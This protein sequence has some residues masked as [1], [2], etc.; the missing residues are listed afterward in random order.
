MAPRLGADRRPQFRSKPR[1][2][3]GEDLSRRLA[4]L[5]AVG[6]IRAIGSALDCLGACIIGVLALP[7][8]LL[9][10]DFKIAQKGLVAISDTH[11]TAGGQ[12]QK[13]FHDI[14][15]EAI[16]ES[17]PTGWMS[18]ALDLRNMLVHR[19]RR[20][21]LSQLLPREQLIFGPDGQP[22]LRVT[23]VEQLPSEPD[24]SQVE[25]FVMV[26]GKPPV[27]TEHAGV[28]LRGLQRSTVY[29]VTKVARELV[30][31]WQTRRTTPGLLSQ[32]AAQWPRGL[33]D[34][35]TSFT[36][37]RPGSAPFEPTHMRVHPDD[38]HRL[39]SAALDDENRPRWTSFDK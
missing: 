1:T 29:V 30:D 5:H 35:K 12:L 28:T 24:K 26:D 14:L 38:A 4:T 13:R 7:K 31:V 23:A 18:W 11:T 36:G 39:K 33:H 27:L 34:M 10:S 2:T 32:P 22:I 17:G 16:K 37:Y 9:Y 19:G 15:D 6:Y 25:A 20:S 8:D 3:P 21:H